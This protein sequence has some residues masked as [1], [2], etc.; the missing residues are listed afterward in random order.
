[1]LVEAFDYHRIADDAEPHL[2]FVRERIAVAHP[3]DKP[4][5]A[6]WILMDPWLTSHTSKPRPKLP[7]F[8]HHR[9]EQL[10]TILRIFLMK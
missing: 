6:S 4:F 5:I 1:M 9:C 3:L 8:W 2:A 7:L 10:R